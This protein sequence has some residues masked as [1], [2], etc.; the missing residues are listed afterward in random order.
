MTTRRER[1]TP[2]SCVAAWPHGWQRDRGP[3]RLGAPVERVIVAVFAPLTMHL[4]RTK[5]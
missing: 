1:S 4:Y 2:T 5:Q 3:D